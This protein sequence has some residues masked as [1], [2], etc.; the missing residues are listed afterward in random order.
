LPP[1]FNPQQPRSQHRR[2]RR[3]PAYTFLLFS[4]VKSNDG[5][6]GKISASFATNLLGE[7]VSDVCPSLDVNSPDAIAS[8]TF[9]D[10]FFLAVLVGLEYFPNPIL[11]ISAGSSFVDLGCASCSLDVRSEDTCNLAAHLQLAP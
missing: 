1:L 10:L 6:S 11:S 3:K 2:R 4:M 5:S 9:F 7:F 8:P